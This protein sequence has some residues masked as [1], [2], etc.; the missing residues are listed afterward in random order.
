MA[1]IN[2]VTHALTNGVFDEVESL[3]LTAEYLLSKKNSL[4]RLN[5]PMTYDREG[6]LTGY[7][8]SPCDLRRPGMVGLFTAAAM[9]FDTITF[10][11]LEISKLRA[12]AEESLLL[13]WSP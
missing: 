7:F 6:L 1:R 13:A 9:K 11:A 3:D 2:Y 10:T 8:G 4:F 5:R 12:D